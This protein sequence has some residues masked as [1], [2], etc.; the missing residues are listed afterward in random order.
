MGH[1]E[2]ASTHALVRLLSTFVEGRMGHVVGVDRHAVVCVSGTM[3][4][5]L[6]RVKSS[7]QHHWTRLLPGEQRKEGRNMG[8]PSRE[9]LQVLIAQR[10]I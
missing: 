1:I 10:Q 9:T 4:V 2:R 6:F 7:L 5:S 3:L 8:G